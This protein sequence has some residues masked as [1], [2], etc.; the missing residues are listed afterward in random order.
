[1]ETFIGPKQFPQCVIQL[2]VEPTDILLCQFELAYSVVKS[3]PT[4]KTGRSSLKLFTE[5]CEHDGRQDA[6]IASSRDEP[7]CGLVSDPESQIHEENID[8]YPSQSEKGNPNGYGDRHGW[9]PD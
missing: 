3:I 9:L 2:S 4:K 8:E 1:M 5:R 7:A 6:P